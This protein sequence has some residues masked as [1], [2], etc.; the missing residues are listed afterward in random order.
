MSLTSLSV[1]C[2]STGRAGNRP[3]PRVAGAACAAGTWACRRQAHTRPTIK[4]SVPA[5][6]HHRLNL[7]CDVRYSMDTP[8]N[9]RRFA[10]TAVSSRRAT[11]AGNPAPSRQAGFAA[12]TRRLAA[13]S[14]R[15]SLL[16]LLFKVRLP[17]L[18][19]RQFGGGVRAGLERVQPVLQV[20]LQRVIADPE[21]PA[22]LT[23]VA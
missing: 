22:R 5:R 13:L 12:D 6:T 4:T 7:R 8:A 10:T 1:G 2:V 15:R 17:A 3:T 11:S 16:R 9:G 14:G 19:V 20:R 23:L 21:H 18:S